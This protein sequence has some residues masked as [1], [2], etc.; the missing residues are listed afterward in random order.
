MASGRGFDG[1]VDVLGR[2]RLTCA[3]QA[4]RF[5]ALVYLGRSVTGCPEAGR[6]NRFEAVCRR[7]PINQPARDVCCGPRCLFWLRDRIIYIDFA[8]AFV[9]A[10]SDSHLRLQGWRGKGKECRDTCHQGELQVLSHTGLVLRR[11]SLYIHAKN[12]D[13]L[14]GNL[15]E[16]SYQS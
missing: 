7:A 1:S 5:F 16:N 12:C 14:P 13:D 6:G 2:E 8:S 9:S 4:R 11:A 10:C 3:K 15:T